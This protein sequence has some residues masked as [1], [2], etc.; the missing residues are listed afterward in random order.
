MRRNNIILLV[1]ELGHSRLQGSV[2]HGQK[3]LPFQLF[4]VSVAHDFSSS[5]LHLFNVSN[6]QPRSRPNTI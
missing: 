4:K 6:G 2:I 1:N 3:R 5:L